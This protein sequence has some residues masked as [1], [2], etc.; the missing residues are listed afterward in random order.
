[1]STTIHFLSTWDLMYGLHQILFE[2]GQTRPRLRNTNILKLFCGYQTENRGR[3]VTQTTVSG[4]QTL[5]NVLKYINFYYS[6]KIFLQ[7]LS[8][9][10]SLV[11]SLL[12]AA[13][14]AHILYTIHD[15]RKVLYFLVVRNIYFL[16][17]ILLRTYV[18][19]LL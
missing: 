19:T 7:N 13:L 9:I 1:M 5:G 6:V 10:Y 3:M 2:Y 11:H 16:L 17:I 18:T 15:V 14:T 12:S 8:V 4:E